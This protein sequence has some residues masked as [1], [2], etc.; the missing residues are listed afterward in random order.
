MNFEINLIIL[1]KQFFQ[2]DKKVMIS[3]EQKQLLKMKQKA[4]FI[5]FKELSVKQITQFF[6]GRWE[7]DFNNVSICMNIPAYAYASIYLNK[8]SSEY[9]KISE[10]VWC[11]T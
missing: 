9:A 4:F 8:Q 7:S 2:H 6:L 5:I 11:S 3:W 1:I 10:C